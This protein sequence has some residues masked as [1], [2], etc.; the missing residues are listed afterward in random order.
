MK[1][2]KK[3]TLRHKGKIFTDELSKKI[4]ISKEISQILKNRGVN[5]Q[6]D[7]EIFMNPSL[8]YLRDPFL[9]KDMDKA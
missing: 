8:G 7:S 2:T 4:K 1:F 9:M 3:W 6:K 5:S